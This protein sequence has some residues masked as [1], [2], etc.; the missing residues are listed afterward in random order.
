M[1][2]MDMFVPRSNYSASTGAFL[3]LRV[4]KGGCNMQHDAGVYALLDLQ[5]RNHSLYAVRGRWLRKLW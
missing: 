5:S 2:S 1:I 3:A 4:A